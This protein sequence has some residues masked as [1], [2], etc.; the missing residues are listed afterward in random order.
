MQ[1]NVKNA[2]LEAWRQ[3]KSTG[4][5]MDLQRLLDQMM[6]I[7]SREVNKWAAAMSRSLLETEAKRLAVE[8][9]KAYD[10]NKGVA[11]STFLAS[12]LPKLSRTVYSNQNVARLSETKTLLFNAYNTA[13]NDLYNLHGREPT[14]DELSD[15]LGWGKKKL[16]AF[17]RQAHRKEYVES[18][19]HPYSESGDDYLADY[20]YHGLTPLQKSIFEHST[21]YLGKP[22]LSGKQMMSQ[23]KITQGQ[24]SYQKKMIEKVVVQATTPKQ[25]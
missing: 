21:G 2:D 13:H 7:I 22:K 25:K 9:F 24:L 6:P 10:P 17:Q 23:L 1:P 4:S 14:N 15:S 16:E 3:W 12:R 5:P 11:L 20:V 18:E 8:A 19:D